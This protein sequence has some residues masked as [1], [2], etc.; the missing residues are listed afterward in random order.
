MCGIIGYAG[1]VSNIS[2]QLE[3]KEVTDAT[4]IHFF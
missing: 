2:K 1:T 4:T 3:G